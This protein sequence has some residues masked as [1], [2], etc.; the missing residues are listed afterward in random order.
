MLFI[1]QIKVINLA[2]CCTCPQFNAKHSALT[3][4]NNITFVGYDGTDA[5]NGFYALETCGKCKTHQVR[6]CPWAAACA[7]R[8]IADKARMSSQLTASQ[9]CSNA[10][11]WSA[12]AMQQS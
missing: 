1:L 8:G 11:H 10:E 9:S 5:K 7:M 2:F 3:S 12:L 4:L 6:C